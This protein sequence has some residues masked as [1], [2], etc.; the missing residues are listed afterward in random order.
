[1]LEKICRNKKIVI[2]LNQ[3]SE[4]HTKWYC[5][6]SVHFDGFIE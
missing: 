3:E 6:Q 1:M 5:S 2:S 4:R